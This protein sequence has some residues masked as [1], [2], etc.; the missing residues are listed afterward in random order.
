MESVKEMPFHDGVSPICVPEQSGKETFSRSGIIL[1]RPAEKQ[2]TAQGEVIRIAGRVNNEIM[3]N[4]GI[5]W[6]RDYQEM[7][8]MFPEYL[9]LGNPLKEEEIV[10]A[11]KG[12]SAFDAW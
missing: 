9:R 7:L 2:R 11:G 6:D 8:R 1:S 4:G 10:Q 3:G 5:N 12:G